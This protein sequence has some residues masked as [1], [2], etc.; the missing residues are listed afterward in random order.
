M[1]RGRYPSVPFVV[2]AQYLSV[3]GLELSA[4]AYPVGGG[5]R[6]IA[7]IRLVDRLRTQTSAEIRWQTEV[8]MPIAGDLRAWDVV[9]HIGSVTVGVDA[10]TRLRDFQAI[11]RRL[12]LKTRD[13]GVDHAILLVAST[14]SNRGALR[15]LGGAIRNN[16]PM[17][18][19]DALAALKAGRSPN[20]NAIILL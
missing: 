1:E 2:V 10:E 11:D 18:S 14:R 8:P 15:E 19:A 5:L 9:L 16:Y 7:Q 4:R 6:D 20:G 12:A 3:T 13:S 17:S